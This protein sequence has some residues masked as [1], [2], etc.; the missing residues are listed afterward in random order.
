[1]TWTVPDILSQGQKWLME[2]N[3]L[4]VKEVEFWHCC[5]DYVAHNVKAGIPA[6]DFQDPAQFFK[7][8]D[9]QH[10]A[11][12]Q[13]AWS[14]DPKAPRLPGLADMLT[15]LRVLPGSEPRTFAQAIDFHHDRLRDWARKN[16]HDP[17]NLNETKEERE[18]RL[19]RDRMRRKRAK[20]ADVDIT[21]PGEMELVRA[22][23]AAKEN[24]K[25]G[26]SWLR[27]QESAAKLA[28]DAA[29][30]QAKLHRAQTVSACQ[31]H[32]SAAEQKVLDAERAL[33]SYRINK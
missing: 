23:R 14:P 16:K 28:Y 19:A 32:V 20:D 9:L 17:D 12:V 5:T 11:N 33:S 7:Q 10:Y 27:S 6:S 26:K 24:L 18:R 3:P 1:M 30:E 15:S 31:Q 25:A 29:V 8:G 13:S 22:L 21:D 2:T 4:H